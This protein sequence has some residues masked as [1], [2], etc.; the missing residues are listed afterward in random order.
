MFNVLPYHPR[1]FLFI[2]STPEEEKEIDSL[3]E[4]VSRHVDQNHFS[5]PVAHTHI[6]SCGIFWGS[7]CERGKL[8]RSVCSKADG[9]EG[10]KNNGR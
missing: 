7:L 4:Y 3:F 6:Q 10:Y 2:H 5:M 9:V 8:F 1:S